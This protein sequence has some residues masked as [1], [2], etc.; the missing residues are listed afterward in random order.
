M[1]INYTG[2]SAKPHDSGVAVSVIVVKDGKILLM[3]RQGGSTGVGTWSIPGGGVEY[4]EDPLVA[5]SRELEEE[6][7]LI[8][9]DFELLGYSNDTHDAENLHYVTFTFYTDKFQGEPKI[10]EPHKCSEIGWF[11]LDS[12]PTPLYEPTAKKL[13]LKEVQDRLKII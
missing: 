13:S 2:P 1:S 3:K 8:C 12:L 6:T 9:E 7:N 4:M 10:M 5:V 11:E